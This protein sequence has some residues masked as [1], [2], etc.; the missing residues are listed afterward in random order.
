[1][2]WQ[3]AQPDSPSLLPIQSLPRSRGVEEEEEEEEETPTQDLNKKEE[4][5][6]GDGRLIKHWHVIQYW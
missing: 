1:M 2:L 5:E 6:E 3:Q 4:E